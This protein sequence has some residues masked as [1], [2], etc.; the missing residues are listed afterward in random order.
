MFNVGAI[1][2][3]TVLG[4]LSAANQMS[5]VF[6]FQLASG[7][8]PMSWDDVIA[9]LGEVAQEIAEAFAPV[10]SDEWAWTLYSC[11]TLNDSNVSGLR[12][13]PTGAIGT[14]T[15]SD[16]LPPQTTAQISFSTGRSRKVLKKALMGL[17]EG[18]TGPFGNYSTATI[19]AINT[20]AAFLLLPIESSD[21]SWVYCY[22]LPGTPGGDYPLY[23]QTVK[24]NPVPCVQRRRR[25]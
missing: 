1:F 21:A 18:Q 25:S 23:P 24:T 19:T 20:A 17:T 9:N 12:A 8:T 22:S 5:M 11:A 7:A 16:L 3:L 14:I 4:L 2:S 13:L 10:Q 6:Q 15:T